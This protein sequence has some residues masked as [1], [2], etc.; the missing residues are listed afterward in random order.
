MEALYDRMAMAVAEIP[1]PRDKSLATNILQC[2]TC[3]LRLLSLPEMAQALGQAA[4]GILDLPRTIKDLCGEFAVIDNNGNVSII[5]Q[6]ARDY[7]LSSGARRFSIDQKAAHKQMFL[8]SMQCLM[9]PGLRGR[10]G[11]SQQPDYL[12][13]AAASW[14]SH[15]RNS[16]FQDREIVATLKKFLTRPW[17]LTWIQA[18]AATGQLRVAIHTSKDL[19]RVVSQSQQQALALNTLDLKL[20]SN[21]SIDLLRVVGRFGGILQRKPDSIYSLIPPFCPKGSAIHQ[22]FG[23]SG[24]LSVGGLSSEAWDDLLARI[25][26]GKSFA[27]SIQAAGSLLAVLASP[28]V[29]HLYDSSDFRESKSSPIQHGERVDR[30]QLN[31]AASLVATYGYRTT[32]VWKISSGE[33]VISVESVKTKT[34]PLA[35]MF[36]E[37][38]SNLLVGTCDRRVRSL[39]LIQPEPAWE[40]VAELDEEM[41]LEKHFTNS[42]S[43]VAFSLDGTLVAVAYRRHP[44][45]AWE[46]DGPLHIGHCRRQN[47][48][49][50]VRELRE[51]VWHPYQP[52][53][54]G[55]TVE[56]I[57]FKWA[58][59]D[60]TVCELPAS[61]TKL[62]VSNDGEFF[63]TG[64]AYGRLK[65]YTTSNFIL[66]HHVLAQEAVLGLTFSP[67]SKRFYDI[68]GYHSNIW[69]PTALAKHMN[70]ARSKSNP[71]SEV[72]FAQDPDLMDVSSKVA[73]DPITALSGSPQ[74][75]LYCVGTRIGGFS[76]HDI[77]NGRLAN[78]YASRAKFAI[79]H[80]AWSSD[81]RYFCCSDFSKQVIIFAVSQ[82]SL[83]SSP[84]YEQKASISMRQVFKGPITQILFHNESEHILLHSSSRIH[85][86]SL[87]SHSVEKSRDLDLP[88]HRCILYPGNSDLI[89]GIGQSKI[90]ILDWDLIERQAYVFDWQQGTSMN[91]G[92]INS[93]Y[94]IERAL[95]THDQA[96]ILLQVTFPGDLSRRRQFYFMDTSA[97]SFSDA[98]DD[99]GDAQTCDLRLQRLAQGFSEEV[100]LALDCL[101]GDRLLYISRNFAICSVQIN[102]ASENTGDPHT[103]QPSVETKT[104]ASRRG[105]ARPQESGITEFYALPGDWISEDAMSLCRFWAV[106]RSLLYPRNGETAV[107]RCATLT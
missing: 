50:T 57:V 11:R 102:W 27:S 84:T 25:S 96:H 12:D 28:G 104:A 76:L 33:C 23:K 85:V 64:D 21:W 41:E 77:Q 83:E 34:R 4:A 10:L 36:T 26:L 22:Q 40:I 92:R 39:S 14:S 107:V 29:I 87:A 60:N 48:L 13:Y 38:D 100:R 9:S 88:M 52:E 94:H 24:I 82:D 45:S 30:I 1:N 37:D 90:L 5:H 42:A 74:G 8:S 72:P 101:W 17:V 43:H 68:R 71:V 3:S 69:E 55:L 20:L 6:T 93:T 67:D 35:M 54:L 44:I 62:S 46:I 58:P 63:V 18:L 59:Y 32:K 53:I 70:H 80:I 15:L 47:E 73:I 78:L 61:A 103:T 7:L 66:L 2:L 89:I 79:E 86:V 97:L 81:G 56:G 91:E 75:R 98:Y 19:S 99:T 16:S 51:L 31:K 106:E 95:V 65:L 49:S 105:A